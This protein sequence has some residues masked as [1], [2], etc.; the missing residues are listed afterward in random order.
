MAGNIT[1][2]IFTDPPYNLAPKTFSGFG[3]HPSKGFV[4]GVGE[5]TSDQFTSFLQKVFNNMKS[6]SRK[7]I[8]LE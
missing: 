8:C 2:M 4:M 1:D 6:Y 7:G 5:M 3:K